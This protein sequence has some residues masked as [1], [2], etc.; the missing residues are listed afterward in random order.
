MWKPQ[1]LKTLWPSTACYKDSFTFTFTFYHED[2]WGSGG[3]TPLFLTSALD[4]GERSGII[5]SQNF[6]FR[7]SIGYLTMILV[8]R[9]YASDGWMRCDE[10]EK[11][12]RKRYWCNRHYPVIWLEAPRKIKENSVRIVYILNTC[13]ES[14][15]VS[16]DVIQHYG[17]LSFWTL[18]G[19]LDYA[20]SS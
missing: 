2:I 19:M 13:V 20:Q 10:L 6:F 15:Q 18:S 1:C 16:D 4:G 12:G 9:L 7:V 3:I 8:V 17:L 5:S 14:T 11:F